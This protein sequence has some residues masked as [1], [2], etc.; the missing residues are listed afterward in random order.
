MFGRPSE[1][2]VIVVAPCS[3]SDCFDMAIEAFRLAVRC[4]C[5]V[6]YLSDGYIAN[7]AEPWLIPDLE[8]IPPIAV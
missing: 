3:P 8:S 1:S 7:G 6:L 5:P 2:P 4:M